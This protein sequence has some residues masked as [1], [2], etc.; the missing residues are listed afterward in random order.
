MVSTGSRQQNKAP[1][2]IIFPM[3]G[4]TGSRARWTPRGVSSSCLSRAFCQDRGR[5]ERTNTSCEMGRISLES[6]WY[7]DYHPLTSKP[8]VSIYGYNSF[9]QISPEQGDSRTKV[10]GISPSPAPKG[11]R[12]HKVLLPHASFVSNS[13]L[14]HLEQ[15]GWEEQGVQRRE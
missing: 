14:T 8:D 7:M 10:A 15:Q 13:S 2:R 5:K 9:V 1:N 11:T 6:H 12:T 3:W 4:S